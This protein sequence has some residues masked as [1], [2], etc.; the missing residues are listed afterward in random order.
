MTSVQYF[1]CSLCGI[2]GVFCALLGWCCCVLAGRAD[3][4][5]AEG[6][7]RG[8]NDELPTT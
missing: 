1:A 7:V 4:A 6:R 2:V 8:I 3:A 5:R